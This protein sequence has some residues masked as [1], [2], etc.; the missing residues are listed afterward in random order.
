MLEY[1]SFQDLP[2]RLLGLS[3]RG[4]GFEGIHLTSPPFS[5]APDQ[6]LERTPALADRLLRAIDFVASTNRIGAIT[7]PPAI[8]QSVGVTRVVFSTREIA[9]T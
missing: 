8:S 1:T 5:P 6:I 4:L 9:S 2:D 3:V 7:A